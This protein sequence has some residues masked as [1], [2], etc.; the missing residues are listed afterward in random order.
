[1]GPSVTLRDSNWFSHS[2]V[3]PYSRDSFVFQVA[4]INLF[5]VIRV[6][7]AFLPLV[8]EAHGR[9]VNVASIMGRMGP[10]GRSPYCATKFAV[11]AISDCLRLEM[12][13][14]GVNVSC[15]FRF[16]NQNSFIW[17]C[18]LM[19]RCRS[20]SLEI[21]SLERPFTPTTLLRRTQSACGTEWYTSHN[22][23]LI[24]EVLLLGL[25]ITERRSA[26]CL[27]Q[28]ILWWENPSYAVLHEWR[29]NMKINYLQVIHRLR[30]IC[31]FEWRF[32]TSA[33]WSTPWRT[34][35]SGRIRAAVTNPWRR[36]TA[37]RWPW[38][39]ICRNLFSM[40]CMDNRRASDSSSDSPGLL[41]SSLLPIHSFGCF[42]FPP[43]RRFLLSFPSSWPSWLLLLHW[44]FSSARGHLLA[45]RGVFILC[46]FR[47]LLGINCKL[48]LDAD[49]NRWENESPVSI[50][51]HWVN[52]V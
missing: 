4:S 36:W 22:V 11:E 50:M 41:T 51:S 13:K 24:H 31:G 48:G 18:L 21:S 2:N 9:I 47:S 15:H 5:G 17:F 6:T 26:Q 14:F 38:L 46:V 40:A 23:D 7:K 1:M 10:R 27:H 43:C 45:G 8:R 35:F 12:K 3:E 39:P 29:S 33:P 32:P 42:E 20:S 28:G 37:L 30:Y 19:D 34:P 52:L 49:Q 16:A 44:S 25:F